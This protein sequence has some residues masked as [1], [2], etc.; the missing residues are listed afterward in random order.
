VFF[1]RTGPEIARSEGVPLGTVKG[2]IRLG[3]LKLRSMVTDDD[4]LETPSFNLWAGQQQQADGFP[5]TTA[6]PG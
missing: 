5:A 3:M 4:L 2:R 1:G 6:C